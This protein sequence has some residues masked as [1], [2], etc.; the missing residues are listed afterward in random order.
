MFGPRQSSHDGIT[1]SHVAV[2]ELR[3]S[4]SGSDQK[5]FDKFTEY[6]SKYR[7]SYADEDELRHRY[8]IFRQTIKEMKSRSLIDDIN[9][10]HFTEFTDCLPEES[11]TDCGFDSYVKRRV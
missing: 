8:R 5:I 1:V 7:R 2:D 3:K 11:V 10:D 6:M 9:T 4:L